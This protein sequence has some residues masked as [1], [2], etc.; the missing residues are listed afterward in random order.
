MDPFTHALTGVVAG[1]AFIFEKDG[2][3]S[4]RQWVA[5]T[6]LVLGAVFPDLDL[7]ANPFE[8]FGLG[9]I[10]YHRAVTHSVVCLPVFAMLLATL[11]VWFCRWRR[12]ERPSWLGLSALFGAGIGLHILF[13]LITSFGTMVWSPLSW[14][15]VSWDT[16]FIVDPFLTLI[17]FLPLMLAWIYSRA[18]KASQRTVFFWLGLSVAASAV[19][20]VDR[21]FQA[22][23]ASRGAGYENPGIAWPG[24]IW[25][26]ALVL[27]ALAILLG[28]PAIGR[29]GLRVARRNWFVGGIV[30]TGIYLGLSA[31]AHAVALRRVQHFA[32]ERG[33]EVQKIGALP[34]PPSF[35]FWSGLISTP[36]KVYHSYFSLMDGQAPQFRDYRQSPRDA[37]VRQALELPDVQTVLV[38]FRFPLLLHQESS[39]SRTTN[40]SFHD[41]RFLPQTG[42]TLPFSYEVEIDKSTGQVLYRGKAR[43]G[44][45]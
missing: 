28:A 16:T 9:T 32:R 5:R 44:P 19:V 43:T 29:R 30:V 25:A 24:A 34:M 31:G 45:R 18:E 42:K 7:I 21:K 20:I 23:A 37:A 1:Q 12:L 2:M 14:R 41:L 40:F 11:A 6:A 13:D 36:D 38:F 15:Y 27:L 39:V 26:A 22:I 17:L 35:L 8:P 4:A 10:H 33:L 3:G